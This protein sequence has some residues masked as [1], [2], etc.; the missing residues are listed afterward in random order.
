[1][2][3]FVSRILIL[4]SQS[5]LNESN[6][7][8]QVKHFIN[9]KIITNLTS[10]INIFLSKIVF[11]LY[12]FAIETWYQKSNNYLVKLFFVLLLRFFIIFR[13]HIPWFDGNIN[14]TISFVLAIEHNNWYSKCL[15]I[16]GTP[17]LV[18]NNNN[19]LL[20]NERS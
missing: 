17:I 13:Y 1:M 20:T 10:L 9:I 8:E 11:G 15:C 3:I 12:R 16:F 5:L 2:H 4:P 19:N 6:I 7:K 14:S 18:I